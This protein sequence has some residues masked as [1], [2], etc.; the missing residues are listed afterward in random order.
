MSCYSTVVRKTQKHSLEKIKV[1]PVEQ[2]EAFKA[3]AHGS[4]LYLCDDPAQALT[5][6]LHLEERTGSSKPFALKH[7]PLRK[8]CNLDQC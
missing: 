5:P 1:V 2:L 4:D 6:R 7:K 8:C 3:A